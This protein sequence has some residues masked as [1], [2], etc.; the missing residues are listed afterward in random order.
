MPVSN[1][2][3][4]GKYIN[5]I[6]LGSVVSVTLSL[7]TSAYTDGDV[8]AATQ[9]VA[10]AVRVSGG[11]AIL[12]SVHVIDLDDQGVGFD[13][14][15]LSANSALGTENSAPDIDDTE[16]LDTIGMVRIGSGDYIDLGANRIATLSGLGLPLKAAEGQTSLW[17]A[18]VTRGT[19]T[20]SASGL[21]LKLGFLWD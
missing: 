7:D 3:A 21:R 8:L 2:P 1:G 15:F 13:L 4:E 14:I 11:R 18:A 19:P 16:V 10:N 9:E 12:Q 6:G 17:V 5:A 20:Y